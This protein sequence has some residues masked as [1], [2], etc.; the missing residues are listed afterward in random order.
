MGDVQGVMIG[1]PSLIPGFNGNAL[2]FDG[3][4]KYV[5]YDRQD[6]CFWDPR[7]CPQ[8]MTFASWMIIFSDQTDTITNIFDSGGSTK[9]SIGYNIVFKS[10]EASLSVSVKTDLHFFYYGMILNK[11]LLSNWIHFVFVWSPELG[12]RLYIDGC[13]ADNENQHGY[14]TM[15]P[16]D[17][18]VREL[19]HLFVG[20][21]RTLEN[22]AHVTFQEIQFRYITLSAFE[23]WELYIG[24]F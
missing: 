22:Y 21:K 3:N 2:Y 4:T 7:E 18:S 20:A 1:G 5:K 11:H 19:N 10:E 12:I 17:R 9:S 24:D 15:E 13:D 14:A 6:T 16:R 23:I 8:G